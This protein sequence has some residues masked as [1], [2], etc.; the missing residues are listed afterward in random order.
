MT[1]D[2]RT[3][4]G[5]VPTA[6]SRT[7]GKE[8]AP[9]ARITLHLTP[10]Q[11]IVALVDGTQHQ[12]ADAALD[13]AGFTWDRDGIHTLSL[14][15]PDQAR[16]A[17]A[18]LHETAAHCQT[19]IRTSGQPYLGDTAEHI[20][21]LLPGT[22]ISQVIGLTTQEH[23]DAHAEALWSS[24]GLA[25]TM[26]TTRLLCAA[27][28]RDNTRELLLIQNPVNGSYQ[29]TA[30]VPRLHDALVP[31]DHGPLTITAFS[32]GL[33]AR[34]IRN[35]L[36]PD[37]ERALLRSRLEHVEED[38][39]RAEHL[40]AANTPLSDAGVHSALDH[41]RIHA[42]H[43]LAAARNPANGPQ[44]D[45][46]T[47]ALERIEASLNS[48]SEDT[49]DATSVWL[50]HGRTLTQLARR[51]SDDPRPT[52]SHPVPPASVALPPPSPSRGTARNR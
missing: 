6:V 14:A 39:A 17:L 4:A 37:Y 19:T 15:D 48:S 21:G 52:P 30:L 18:H 50:T 40:I 22:W 32:P 28:L 36:L 13:L 43:L 46:V 24:S 11:H 47:A 33:A 9:A 45:T 10:K 25:E 7:S 2:Y 16:K 8:S 38:L 29:A 34:E 23:Q 27:V 41:F 44:S 3:Y 31:S 51:T 12:W 26:D 42:P 35:Q 1:F 49:S 5:G 20:T